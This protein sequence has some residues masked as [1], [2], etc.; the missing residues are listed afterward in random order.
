M[1]SKAITLLY[2]SA[3]DK[4]YEVHPT[5]QYHYHIIR[6]PQSL[7]QEEFSEFLH[8]HD[9]E[10]TLLLNADEIAPGQV[11]NIVNS[12]R[13]NA[14]NKLFYGSRHHSSLLPVFIDRTLRMAT[15]EILNA[16]FFIG[17]TALFEKAYA[18]HDL[19]VNPLRSIAFSLQKNFAGLSRLPG[20]FTYQQAAGNA[21]KPEKSG[22]LNYRYQI[23]LP[24]RYLLSGK[25]FKNFFR[26]E[27]RLRRNMVCR[28]FMILFAVFTFLFMP[29]ISKDYGISGDEFVD[30]RH[31]GYVLDYYLHGDKTA[32]H[33]PKT[34]LHFYGIS[35]QI[36]AEGICRL[37]HA[38]DYFAVRHAL[39]AFVGAGGIWYAGLLGLRWGGDLCGLLSML[40]LFF[41]PRY[42]GNSMNNMKDIPFATGYIMAVFYFI[43]LFD[44]YP[45]FRL[46][47]IIGAITG[48][49]IAFGSRSGGLILYPYLLM[50]AGLFYIQQ[51]GFKEFYKFYKYRKEVG[52]IFN[53]LLLVAVFSYILSIALWPYALEHPFSGVAA[54]L[55]QFTNFTA[56]LRLMY[57][58]KE[59]M[60]NMVPISYAPT[61]LSIGLPVI[62]LTGVAGY[63]LWIC[64]KREE[65]SLV[66]WLLL[67]AALFPVCWVMYKHSNLYGGIRHFMFI[68]TI[69]A[70]IAAKFWTLCIQHAN[71]IP[72]ICLMLLIGVLLFL[73]FSH[74]VRNHPHEYIY[75]NEFL[76]GIKNAYGRYDT[77][78]YFNSL[79]DCSEWFKKNVELPR[80]RK[81]VIMTN[82]SFPLEQYFKKDTNVKVIYSRY[83]E[84]Y[85]KDWDYAIIANEYITP[86]QL[87]NG[88]FPPPGAVYTATVDGYAVGAVI[89]RTDKEEL[90]SFRL[91][92]EQK[93]A[94]ALQAFEKYISTH[95][96]APEE[97]LSKMAKLY[98]INKRTD[99]AREYADKALHKHPALMEALH[100]SVLINI[101]QHDYPAALKDAQKMLNVN[102]N[103]FNGHYLKA[104]TKFHLKKYQEAIDDLN[105][106]LVINPKYTPALVLAGDIMSIHKNYP[107]AVQLYQKALKIKNDTET[108]AALASVYC[109]M[110]NYGEMEKTLRSISQ[111][112]P[113][114]LP[115]Y[116][117]QL[118]FLLQENHLQEAAQQL[119]ELDSIQDNSELFVLRALYLHA[120]Q[121]NDEAR[122]M[123]TKALECDP[124]NAEAQE[125][126][127]AL[128]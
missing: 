45:Y 7:T 76:G 75:F 11:G 104:L 89:K 4:T 93:P 124:D 102:G 2:Y 127:K 112:T 46:R 92:R 109:K 25:F 96:D 116:L 95:P 108:S 47:Y 59:I 50:Y 48:I 16:S 80:D 119:R 105:K 38:E 28:L 19:S 100:M 65:F 55:K 60:S 63:I 12:Y 18:A 128:K 42:F 64:I 78:Y 79:K 62:L 87:Q 123:L 113:N 39:T 81:T 88:L 83:Y 118:R 84:K 107:T 33:Q 34:F 57:D 70:V 21:G 15:P 41:T 20:N 58:G 23:L 35:M 126:Q 13:Q 111:S 120:I 77:D 6:L 94:A 32:V 73:P 71:R 9:T 103:S 37:F 49:A 5:P 43:R 27:D 44:F 22:L 31:A 3:T 8:R 54:S 86:N 10:D 85:S 14:K 30:Q 74:M 121:K 61:F 90:E 117:V 115:A 110:K 82:L 40:L 98:Y 97:V 24:G 1:A 114:Y 36:V 29:Y 26:P 69:G 51:V 91:E 67:F 53:I 106:T 99:K 56:A 101:Q 72:K 52:N 66:S 68:I 122:Q 125:L 17:K